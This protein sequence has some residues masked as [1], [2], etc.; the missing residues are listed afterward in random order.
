MV[1]AARGHRAGTDVRLH[2]SCPSRSRSGCARRCSGK[3][4]HRRAGRWTLRHFHR[5]RGSPP[6]TPNGSIFTSDFGAIGQGLG[7]AIG[8]AR[9]AGGRRVTAVL[10]DGCLMMGIAEL[11]TV[12]RLQLPLTLFVMN[13]AGYGQERHS[14]VAKGFSSREAEQPTPDL[15]DV[16]RAAGLVPADQHVRR[17]PR[18]HRAP[19]W[20]RRAAV[21]G[22]DD[23]RLGPEPGRARS[24]NAPPKAD[25]D[26]SHRAHASLRHGTASH[27]VPADLLWARGRP[28]DRWS[29]PARRGGRCCGGR[30]LGSGRAGPCA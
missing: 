22:C 2:R 24:S 12:A 29:A 19:C 23:R 14:L 15:V 18:T 7:V 20:C 3:R 16:A 17:A 10:G 11:E 6:S 9:G 21:R 26:A 1:D 13:D 4:P 27:V 25:A 28:H 5:R 8:A 30:T